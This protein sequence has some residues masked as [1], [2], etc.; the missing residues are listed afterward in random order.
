[1][2]EDEIAEEW[3]DWILTLDDED[4]DIVLGEDYD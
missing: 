2:D 1:M 4:L 3:V